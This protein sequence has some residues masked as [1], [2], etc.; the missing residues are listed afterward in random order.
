LKYFPFLFVA[1]FDKFWEFSLRGQVGLCGSVG[2]VGQV[3]LG[4]SGRRCALVCK[5]RAL[6]T[7][8]VWAPGGVCGRQV[9]R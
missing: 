9:G 2:L 6:V 8:W 7:R 4:A 3:G 5:G 1:D